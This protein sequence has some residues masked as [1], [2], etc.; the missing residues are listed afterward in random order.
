M[1]AIEIVYCQL[2][3]E[4]RAKVSKV[5]RNVS[6]GQLVLVPHMAI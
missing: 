3:A 6:I 5:F 1:S 2:N 4:N